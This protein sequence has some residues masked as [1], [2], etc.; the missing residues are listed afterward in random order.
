MLGQDIA[1]LLK[2]SLQL[3]SRVLS[4]I[5]AAVMFLSASEISKALYRCRETGSLYW[6]DLEK[7]VNRPASLEFRKAAVEV[8]P[9]PQSNR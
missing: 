2:L 7:R 1:I 5:L 9:L 4:K 8:Q 6:T 3:E